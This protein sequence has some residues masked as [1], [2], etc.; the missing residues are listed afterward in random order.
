MIYGDFDVGRKPL[1]H[2]IG[3]PKFNG[4]KS[5]KTRSKTSK[6]KVT[7]YFNY[8]IILHFYLFLTL[9]IVQSF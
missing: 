1:S 8:N 2:F 6:H 4:N 7:Q 9:V 5:V 3:Y